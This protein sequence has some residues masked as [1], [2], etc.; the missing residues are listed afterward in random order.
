MALATILAGAGQA[1]A[2]PRRQGGQ[3][4][5]EMVGVTWY[6][7]AFQHA[8]SALD[9]AGGGLTLQ[10]SSDGQVSGSAGCNN[11]NGSYTAGADQQLTIS[12]LASTR[13][14]CTPDTV[15]TRE[16]A[17]LQALPAT[18]TYK[19]DGTSA[20]TLTAGSDTL[21]Y[22][23]A[24]PAQLPSTGAGADASLTVPAIF[25]ALMLLAGLWLRRRLAF[26]EST[27]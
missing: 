9:V 12:E 21:S 19:L 22:T 15:M 11:Y 23:T 7:V 20:L 25:G 27:R 2:A 1:A 14:F 18:T 8:G 13:M 10:F 16:A 5:A 3:L 6:L 17:Y 24:A 26:A 4:P